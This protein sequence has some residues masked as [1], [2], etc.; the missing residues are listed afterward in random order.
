MHEVV[1][2]A[3]S[4]AVMIEIHR[5][6]YKYTITLGLVFSPY[7]PSFH[8]LVLNRGFTSSKPPVY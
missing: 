8:L 7:K 1:L 3:V 4:A 6:P 2:I 5:F